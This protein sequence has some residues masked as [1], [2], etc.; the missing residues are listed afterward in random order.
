MSQNMGNSK[1][2]IEGMMEDYVRYIYSY[3]FSEMQKK[4]FKL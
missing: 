4:L 1:A 2:L 3:D